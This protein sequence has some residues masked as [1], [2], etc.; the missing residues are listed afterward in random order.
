MFEEIE[1]KILEIN[2]QKIRAILKKEK[3]KFIKKV[4]QKN[5]FFANDYI[6]NKKIVV[7]IRCDNK[8][9]WLTIKSPP[10]IINNHKVRK[11]YE[12]K[13]Q[14][15]TFGEQMLALTG[16][17]EVGLYEAKREY[18]QL[19]HCSIEIILLPQIPVYLEIEGSEKETQKGT[20]HL[21]LYTK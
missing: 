13:L 17:K 19:N 20:D 5:V 8:N 10:K 6:K 1:I 2:P 18:Y 4:L 12:L 16:F 3:A 7:R 14:N 11:E 15:F 9:C 21:Q